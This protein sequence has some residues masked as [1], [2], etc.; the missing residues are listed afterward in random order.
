[1]GVYLW[2]KSLLSSSL[3]ERGKEGE[4]EHIHIA[5]VAYWF[6]SLRCLSAFCRQYQGRKKLGEKCIFT[7]QR[8]LQS[9]CESNTLEYASQEDGEEETAKEETASGGRTQ[10]EGGW[11]SSTGMSLEQMCCI[12]TD[13]IQYLEQAKN[14]SLFKV[15]Y[16]PIFT[17]DDEFPNRAMS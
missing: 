14:F 13:C 11:K 10:T 2:G 5:R 3:R 6:L 8:C 17:G 9:S 4:T 16:F 1:M 15:L 12:V 7:Y